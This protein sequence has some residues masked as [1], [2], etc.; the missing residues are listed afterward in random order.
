MKYKQTNLP[1]G[2]KLYYVKNRINES[3]VV[4]VNFDCGSRF[5]WI[6][7]LA[8]FTEHMFFTGTKTLDK[9]E[10]SKKYYDFIHV[11]AGTNILNIRFNGQIFTK[12]FS[13]YLS[14]VATMI[15][16]S[17]FSEE[18]VQKE[19][20]VVQQEIA[21]KKDK[22]KYLS[23]M[24]SEYLSFGLEE[25]KYGNLG[26]KESVASITSEDVKKFVEKYFISNNLEVYVSSPYSLNKVKKLVIKNLVEKLPRNDSFIK[27]PFYYYNIKNSNFFEVETKPIPKNYIYM[28]FAMKRNV[29][30]FDFKC[31]F[32]L[33]LDMLNDHSEGMLNALRLKKSLVYGAGIYPSYFDKNSQCE[34][35]T[36]C[37]KENVNEIIKTLAEY[38]KEVSKNGFTQ[39]QLDKAKR[40]YEFGEATKEVKLNHQVNKLYQFKYFGKILKEK[41]AKKV[42]KA[43]TLEEVNALFR[44]VFENPTVSLLVYGDATKEDVMDKKK[45]DKVFKMQK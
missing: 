22:F 45:F 37:D 44:E 11:N 32:G 27:P 7:G 26:T 2:A 10:I 25:F 28:N 23:E 34:F 19:I 38:L 5:N 18:N 4:D 16:E 15:T 39:A 13:D 40:L 33:V 12:E 29:W 35:A 8:H 42:I 20:P 31:K 6:P 36:E 41:E 9:E 14:T 3:T 30:D 24:Y 17:T 21:R 1:N 43:T